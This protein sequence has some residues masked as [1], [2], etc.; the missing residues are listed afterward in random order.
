MRGDPP[1]HQHYRVV[2][3]EE[4]DAM[5]ADRARLRAKVRRQRHAY[6]QLQAAYERQLWLIENWQARKAAEEGKGK[7]LTLVVDAL[8]TAIGPRPAETRPDNPE[9]AKL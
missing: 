7:R 4:W 1:D 2:S 8:A 3:T 6:R 5:Q 9:P